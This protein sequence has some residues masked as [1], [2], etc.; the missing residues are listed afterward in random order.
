MLHFKYYSDLLSNKYDKVTSS[1]NTDQQIS[2]KLL[3]SAAPDITFLNSKERI[4]YLL[5]I[6]PFTE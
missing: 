1:G 4:M 5:T 2:F 6:K 3:K